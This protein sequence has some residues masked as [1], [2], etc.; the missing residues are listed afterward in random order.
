MVIRQALHLG[1]FLN[2]RIV[3][4]DFLPGGRELFSG[5]LERALR[6]RDDLRVLLRD[7]EAVQ[8]ARLLFARNAALKALL[9]RR[10]ALALR[11]RDTEAL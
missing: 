4:A 11:C 3:D 10:K 8:K 7:N 5:L 1:N 6:P 9:F 2:L